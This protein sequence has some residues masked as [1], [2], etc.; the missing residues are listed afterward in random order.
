MTTPVFRNLTLL[1]FSIFITINVYSQNIWTSSITGFDQNY[2]PADFVTASNGDI[3]INGVKWDSGIPGYT[4]KL[5]KST[6]QGA[7]WSEVNTT[8]LEDLG[9]VH[10]LTFSGNKMLL[11]GAHI[12]SGNGAKIF[13]SENCGATWTLSMT[14]FDQSYG[15]M[16]FVTASNGDVY[17]NGV[18]FD[19]GLGGFINKLYKST[20]QGAS[21]TEVSTSGLT[22][23][24]N[25]HSLTISEDKMLLSGSHF[26]SGNGAKIF[27]SEDYGATWSL[28]MIGFDQSYG[29]MDFVTAS[30]G[31]VYVNG[32][33]W[34]SGMTAYINKLYKSTN[35]GASWSEVSTTGLED[36]GNVHSL[37]ISGDKMLIAGMN[38]NTS[39]GALILTSDFD[40][41]TGLANSTKTHPSVKCFP[42]PFSEVLNISVDNI[43][44][45]KSLKVTT[46]SGGEVYFFKTNSLEPLIKT[47]N[48]D[49][50]KSGL[51]YL[52][53]EY[54]QRVET[55]KLIKE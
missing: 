6:N 24:G 2:G 8:G 42:N 10:S 18:K 9:N 48:T 51:Y 41:G 37:T 52:V 29:P 45:L 23:L 13:V 11:A 50:L 53:L 40:L 43:E 5:Y 27:V 28:S 1:L 49:A 16:D 44:D 3:Y 47:I 31:D 34:D 26:I 12:I 7:S 17:I 39:N 35:Q 15:P 54:E 21:W 32:V 46:I 33:K 38:F 20:N 14:G 55:V 25:V 36:L 19:S 30:N 4:N 22:D